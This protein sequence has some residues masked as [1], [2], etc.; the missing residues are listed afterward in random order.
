FGVM[1][2][3]TRVIMTLRS[4]RLPALAEQGVVGRDLLRATALCR[5][6][7]REE[8]REAILGPARAA[9]FGFE[10]EAM[11]EALVE[12]AEGREA[13]LPLLSF[14][15][16][17][18]WAARDPRRRV[19]PAAALARIG[20][21]AGALARRA[22]LVLAGLGAAGRAEARRIL[23]GCATGERPTAGATLDAL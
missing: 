21:L 11:V 8:L 14:A 2:A 17:E 22:D 19:I 1:T 18:L 20:G 3:T 13:A 9:G 15:L 4:D 10:S 23:V 5:P 6:M 12:E 7:T 16:A